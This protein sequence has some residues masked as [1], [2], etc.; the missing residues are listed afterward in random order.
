MLDPL[1]E[2]RFVLEQQGHGHLRA[3]VPF[4]H[5][6]RPDAAAVLDA[7]MAL[8]GPRIVGVRMILNYSEEDPALTW[9]QVERGD[10]LSGRVTAFNE[11]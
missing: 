7:H 3:V 5:L 9:P 1:A 10:Y 2:T 8:A 6:G 4:V 11:G